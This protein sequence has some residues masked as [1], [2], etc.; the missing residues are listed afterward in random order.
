MKIR[1]FTGLLVFFLYQFGQLFADPSLIDIFNAKYPHE[2]PKMENL[3]SF[4]ASLSQKSF[5]TQLNATSHPEIP[6]PFQDFVL[7]YLG[8]DKESDQINRMQYAKK[9][10]ERGC[11]DL[12][13][14][15][16]QSIGEFLCPTDPLYFGEEAIQAME[17]L[18]VFRVWSLLTPYLNPTQYPNT[19]SH[20][21]SSRRNVYSHPP[22]SQ[23][24]VRN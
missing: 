7:W 8:Q 20:Q 3:K 16:Y 15:I 12:A 1:M 10:E 23:N 11:T 17:R 5:E 2:L 4:E 13:I 9:L 6:T 24:T 18:K 19:A 14:E 21:R 22:V